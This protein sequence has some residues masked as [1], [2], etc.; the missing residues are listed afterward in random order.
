MGSARKRNANADSN[1]GANGTGRRRAAS[2][3]RTHEVGRLREAIDDGTYYVDARLIAAS[4]MEAADRNDYSE[5]PRAHA[6]P[7][8]AFSLNDPFSEGG[9]TPLES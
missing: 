3:E 8:Y 6:A 2:P 1:A 5:P 9:R 7:S 4:I